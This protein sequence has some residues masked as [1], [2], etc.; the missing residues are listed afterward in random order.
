MTLVY[1]AA[2]DRE[3]PYETQPPGDYVAF[4]DDIAKAKG[5][6][7]A[8]RCYD[9][10]KHPNLNA[11]IHKVLAHQWHPDTEYSIWIDATVSL[12]VPADD[13]AKAFLGDADLAMFPHPERDCIYEEA[14]VSALLPDYWHA[15]FY[16]Y[17]GRQMAAQV[18]SYRE[19]GWPEHAGLVECGVILR[20]HTPA[21]ARFNDLWWSE[22][23]RHT[24]Q[25][26]LSVLVAAQRAGVKIARIPGSIRHGNDF[27]GYHRHVP[28][29]GR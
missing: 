3:V 19:A 10:F 20:R 23:C 9:G 22:I 26:Q 13:F 17:D 21:V 29:Q 8:A 14:A 18:Q 24:F 28:P 16:K 15:G 6:W 5:P 1:T 25:D 4:V 2:T 27:V 7:A 11:K 12:K